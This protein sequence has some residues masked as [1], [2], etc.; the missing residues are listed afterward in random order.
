MRFCDYSKKCYL[1]NFIPVIAGLELISAF[2]GCLYAGLVP[3]CIRPPSSENLQAAL[4]TL[5][6]M[7]ECCN[8]MAVLTTHN[9]TK[10]MTSKVCTT[11]SLSLIMGFP[12]FYLF[13][14]LCVCLSHSF[15]VSFFMSLDLCLFVFT[16][17]STYIFLFYRNYI[18]P[19]LFFA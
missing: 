13:L 11:A 15:S 7:M 17:V 4:P 12:F 2:Y 18:G 14:I 1:S 10:L 3:V 19:F 9:V 16:F 8:I 6:M 5:K